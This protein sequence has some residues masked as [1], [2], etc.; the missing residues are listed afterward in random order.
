MKREISRASALVHPGHLARDDAHFLLEAREVDPQVETAAA[1]RV[2]Q[3]AHA[4]RGQDD[5]RRVRRLDRADLGDRHL[6]VGEHLEQEGLEL[7]VGA[8]DLVDQQ[9][10]R[11]A[12]LAD[13]LEQRAPDQE[14]LGE[15]RRFLL[16]AGVWVVASSS[17]MCR[18]CL[19]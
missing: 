6:E 7:L 13:G 4:V 10:R 8:V 5:V 15:D 1:E 9:H 3:L 19:G 12:V 2:G 11:L 14:G 18:S 17:L 16:A